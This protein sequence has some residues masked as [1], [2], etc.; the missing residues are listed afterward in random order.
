MFRSDAAPVACPFKGPFSF[1]YNR[2]SGECARPPSRIDS[3]AEDSR[4]RMRYQACA[5]VLGSESSCTYT[6]IMWMGPKYGANKEEG[7]RKVQMNFWSFIY[8]QLRNWSAWLRGR[9]V[10]RGTWLVNYNIK[11]PARTRI[12]IVVSCTRGSHTNIRLLSESR[13]VETLLATDCFRPT[14]DRGQWD[15]PRVSVKW[16]LEKISSFIKDLEIRLRSM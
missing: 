8:L 12:D 10:T 14:R 1:T 3:C 6:R 5:D 2:G 9:M 11:W 13:K 7:N 16:V 15:L 4:L